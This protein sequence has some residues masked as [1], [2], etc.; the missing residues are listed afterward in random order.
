[1]DISK[2]LEKEALEFAKNNKIANIGDKI[3]TVWGSWKKPHTVEICKIGATIAYD[4]MNPCTVVFKM[5]YIARRLKADGTFLDEKGTGI[6]LDNIKTIDNNTWNNE[7][8]DFNH[9]GLS[10]KLK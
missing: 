8:E 9:C 2:I 5:N 1:M 3:E 10:W 6:V 7:L 4:R